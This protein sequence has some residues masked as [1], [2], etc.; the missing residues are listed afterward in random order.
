MSAYEIVDGRLTPVQLREVSATGARG[1]LGPPVPP[2]PPPMPCACRLSQQTARRTVVSFDKKAFPAAVAS[3]RQPR[4][5]TRPFGRTEFPMASRTCI[6]SVSATTRSSK[7]MDA[8]SLRQHC[9]HCYC[10][11]EQW[12]RRA[13]ILL[14]ERADELNE[15]TPG[16][17]SRNHI[18]RA[19]LSCHRSSSMSGVA[20]NNDKR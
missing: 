11:V 18:R 1:E 8:D 10:R 19:R 15:V 12:S 17:S 7:T 13:F 20:G 14:N 3:R 5:S 16:S 2:K 4:R 6:T 9:R